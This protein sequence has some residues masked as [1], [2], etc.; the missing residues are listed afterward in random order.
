ML[1]KQNNKNSISH[2]HFIV[3]DMNV[4]ILFQVPVGGSPGVN[5]SLS[6]QPVSPEPRKTCCNEAAQC[7]PP[8]RCVRA[9]VNVCVCTPNAT[10]DLIKKSVHVMFMFA[11][12]TVPAERSA[13]PE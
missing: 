9:D 7:V 5:N 10:N 1:I 12:F 4:T 2:T 8:H 11:R 6:N 13:P 3:S